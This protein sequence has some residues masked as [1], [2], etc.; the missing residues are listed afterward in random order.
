MRTSP[1][2][3]WSADN[4]NY[5]AAVADE[6]ETTQWRIVPGPIVAT[7]PVLVE[8]GR[9]YDVWTNQNMG[10]LTTQH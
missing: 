4:F 7:N 6:L 3:T 2:Y 5:T 1:G 8:M 9:S 10:T